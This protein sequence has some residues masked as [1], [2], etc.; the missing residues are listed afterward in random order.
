VL[1]S[2][3]PFCLYLPSA[4]YGHVPPCLSTAHYFLCLHICCGTV[5]LFF[6]SVRGG[7]GGVVW[8]QGF[9]LAWQVLYHL[10]HASNP[11]CS[12]YFGDRVSLFVQLKTFFPRLVWNWDPDLSLPCSLGWQACATLPSCWLRWNLLNFLPRLASNHE[13]PSLSLPSS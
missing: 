9:I 8:T 1:V 6:F 4:I 7:G 3:S 5:S 12:S 2:N 10:R 11:F 13:S